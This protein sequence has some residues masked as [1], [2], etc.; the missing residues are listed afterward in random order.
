MKSIGRVKV[1]YYQPLYYGTS[2][3]GS[4]WYFV[5]PAADTDGEGDLIVGMFSSHIEC[6]GAIRCCTDTLRA[7]NDNY[8]RRHAD[9]LPENAGEGEV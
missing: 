8:N 3:R 4:G 5:V 7:H 6:A 9:G 2:V 1:K